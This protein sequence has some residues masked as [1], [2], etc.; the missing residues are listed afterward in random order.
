MSRQNHFKTFVRWEGEKTKNNGFVLAKIMEIDY[1]CTNKNEHWNTQKS[2][3][4]KVDWDTLQIIL[5]CRDKRRCQWRAS[6]ARCQ[7]KLP[8]DYKG[9]MPSKPCFIGVSSHPL[10]WFFYKSKAIVTRT[11]RW[12][13]FFRDCR[14]ASSRPSAWNHPLSPPLYILSPDFVW[15]SKQPQK[16]C[17]LIVV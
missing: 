1:L 16:R 12:P 7:R 2:V 17:Q 14:W 11:Q 4:T 13:C 5:K 10:V 9:A 15:R 6:T 3:H 8:E